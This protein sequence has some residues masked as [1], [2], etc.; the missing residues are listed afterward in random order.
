FRTDSNR[1]KMEGDQ[2]YLR[3]PEEMFAA[4]KDHT[5]AL[6]MSQRI[7][8]SV[9]I[10]LDLGQRHFPAFQLPAEKTSLQYLRELCE[11]GLK[12]RYAN[13]PERWETGVTPSPNPS[14]QGGG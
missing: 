10:E 8:D 4:M 2:F 3:S 13:V 5:D 14:P 11:A 9:N 1:M 7:A 6:A 12:E